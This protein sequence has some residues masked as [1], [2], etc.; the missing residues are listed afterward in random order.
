MTIHT[1]INQTIDQYHVDAYIASGGMADVYRATNRS[2]G[3]EVVLKIAHV[4]DETY[5]KRFEREVNAMAKINHAA[6]VTIY[7]V[8]QTPDG[9]P[10]MAMQYIRGGTL[11]AKLDLLAQQDALLTT[12]AVLE[13]VIRIAEGLQAAHLMGIIHRDLKPSN[14]LLHDDGKPAIA[15]FGIAAL[16]MATTLTQRGATIGTPHYMAP[17]Q[18]KGQPADFRSDIYALGVILYE[19][20]IGDPPF[21]AEN[22]QAVLFQHINQA[23]YPV[24][25]RRPDLTSTTAK[26]VMR[27]LAKRPKDRYQDVASLLTALQQARE[28]EAR[29]LY[30]ATPAGSTANPTTPIRLNRQSFLKTLTSLRSY[31][32]PRWVIGLMI[33]SLV[34]LSGWQLLRPRQPAGSLQPTATATIPLATSTLDPPTPV[35]ATSTQEILIAVATP[36]DTPT[37]TITPTPSSTPTATPTATT[38][39]PTN[40]IVFQ[41]NRD[42]DYDLYIMDIDGDNQTRL[43]DNTADDKYP[44]A[45]PDGQT[46][47]FES[48]RTGINE[49][50]LHDVATGTETQLTDFG[51]GDEILPTW[52]P[53]GSQILF[54]DARDDNL[55]VM[56]RNGRNIRLLYDGEGEIRRAHWSVN[57]QI[58]FHMNPPNSNYSQIY[59]IDADGTNQ[60]QLTFTSDNFHA[61]WSPDGRTILYNTLINEADVAIYVMDSNGFGAEELYNSP[62]YDW[63]ASWSPDG[64]SVLLTISITDD[65]DYIYRLN[66]ATGTLQLITPRGSY[67]TWLP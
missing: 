19:L 24:G 41:S 63:S 25:K 31:R 61:N 20:L 4:R 16:Q 57:D 1:I 65:F 38:P 10:Y 14:I 47:L 45:A 32:L 50:Y 66:I 35:P 54:A 56:D 33:L 29:N 52:S 40:R 6:V 5:L 2:L 3:R 46:I 27:C 30:A 13:L 62:D 42:G 37:P 36:T 51:P 21:I 39:P 34:L 17:E 67:P 12:D 59:R 53:D 23:A 26:L 15:D 55:Y 43:T 7:N 64:L 9:R 44:V 49:I 8:G 11:R 22:S 18:A 48:N 28:A 60:Q 58:V